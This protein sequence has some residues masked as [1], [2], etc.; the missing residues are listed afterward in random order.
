M[1]DPKLMYTLDNEDNLVYVRTLG[2]AVEN[3]A[4]QN[5]GSV[6]AGAEVNAIETISYNGSALT[7][8]ASRNVALPVFSMAKLSQADTGY[9]ATYQFTKDGVLVGDKINIPKD[10]VVESGTVETVTV[11]DEPYEG[12]H[13]GD[14]Y[15]DL[16]LA[17]ADDEHIYIPVNDLV[18]VY[19]AGTGISISGNVISVNLTA[20]E[21]PNLTSEKITALTGYSATTTGAVQ[22][23]AATDS[24]NE[25]IAK[26]QYN[27]NSKLTA[28]TAI[29]GATKC[30]ITYDN[31]GLVTAGADLS[32]ADIPALTSEKVTALTGYT[33]TTE[34]TVQDVAATDTLNEA[35]AKLQYAISEL[36]A[37]NFLRYAEVVD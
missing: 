2:I 6:E 26:L 27:V 7:I 4:G 32:L 30:K 36:G 28:N 12:A 18:D 37:G 11:E 23:V 34:G 9:A 16:V 24:L 22:D 35:I 13:V 25:A 21:I 15:I 1:T 29:S 17:N 19:T 10:L 8:D 20:A 14:K 3:T 33:A 31:N 5:L